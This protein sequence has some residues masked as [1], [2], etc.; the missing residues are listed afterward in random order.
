[1][2]AI[3]HDHTKAA[4]WALDVVGLLLA[5]SPVIIFVGLTVAG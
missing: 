5:I 1:M 3:S 4:V 2:A